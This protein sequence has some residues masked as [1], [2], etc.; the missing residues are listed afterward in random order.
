MKIFLFLFFLSSS[1]LTFSQ[2]HEK[3]IAG[4]NSLKEAEAY[5]EEHSDVSVVFLHENLENSTYLQM[6]DTLAVGDSFKMQFYRVRVVELGNKDLYHCSYIFLD[7]RGQSKKKVQKD[8]D[9]IVEKLESGSKFADLHAEY[10]MDNNANSG[11]LGWVDPDH[12]ADGFKEALFSHKNGDIFKCSDDSLGWHYVIQLTD[13]IKKVKGHYVLVYPEMGPMEIA[14][15]IDH[16]ANLKLLSTPEEIRDYAK[17]NQAVNM[18]F[19]NEINDLEFFQ[20]V[21]SLKNNSD[22]ELGQSIDIDGMRYVVLKD[23]TVKLYTFKYIFIDGASVS[24]EER[25]RRVNDIYTRYNAGESFD[26][27]ID[28]YWAAN[29]EYS[30]MTNIESSLL[31]EELVAQL[32]AKGPGELFVARASQSYFVGVPIGKTK[33]AKAYLT[34]SYP[35]LIE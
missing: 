20:V 7:E 17:E 28:A 24:E 19:F 18:H 10:S 26:V 14:E 4:I 22:P 5:S 30:L 8:Q 34:I 25:K 32:D 23:T 9:D 6:K 13:D 29:K 15:T 2:D 33:L 27:L 31:M 21:G 11:N 3:D 35:L 1:L 12:M 16:E